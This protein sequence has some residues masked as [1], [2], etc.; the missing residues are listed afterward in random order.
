MP[1]SLQLSEKNKE[2]ILYHGAD[3]VAAHTISEN[4]VVKL[5]EYT[6]NI[7]IHIK[8][9]GYLGI[10]GLDFLIT[11]D[12]IYFLEVNP[13]YQASSFLINIALKEKGFS[14][15]SKMNLTAFY[16][17]CYLDTNV[18]KIIVNYSFTNI[19]TLTMQSIYIMFFKK[20]FLTS[21]WS[22][23]LLMDGTKNYLLMKMPIVIVLFLERILHP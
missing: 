19:Y 22:R 4:I 16:E 1:I 14:S 15:L 2:R 5:K 12:E 21:M 17:H 10:I 8:Q 23:L 11:K 20:P 18:E 6:N 13:R 3:Y 7:L 9:L